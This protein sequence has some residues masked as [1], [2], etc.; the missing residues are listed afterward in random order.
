[1]SE[2]ESEEVHFNKRVVISCPVPRPELVFR[3]RICWLQRWLGPKGRD[4]R[5]PWQVYSVT[6][7]LSIPSLHTRERE[8]LGILRTMNTKSELTFIFRDL[9]PCYSKQGEVINRV[10]AK[11]QFILCPLN[12][13]THPVASSP[14]PKCINGIDILRNWDHPQIRFLVWSTSS[15]V[16]KCRSLYNCPPYFLWA[17]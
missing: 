11:V 14:V 12:L 4:P 15:V 3:V 10:L 13:K 16:G 9:P 1:M 7:Y 6:R 17:K 2:L 8:Y 5:T